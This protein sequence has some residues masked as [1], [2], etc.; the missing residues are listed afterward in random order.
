MQLVERQVIK[1][2]HRF[3]PEA[4][5]LFLLS[6]KLYNCDNN[7]SGQNFLPDQPMNALTVDRA[8]SKKRVEDKAWPAK[9]TKNTLRLLQ[10]AWTSYHSVTLGGKIAQRHLEAAAKRPDCK[11]QTKKREQG[12]YV[13]VFNCQAAS[14]KAFAKGYVS[15]S[16]TNILRPSKVR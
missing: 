3:Y 13:V 4:D 5:R 10:K 8:R 1:P 11:N 12:R 2:N 7:I 14:K 6:K 9:V 15:Q 16:A